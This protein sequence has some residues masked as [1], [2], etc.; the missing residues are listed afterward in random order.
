MKTAKLI[1]TTAVVALATLTAASAAQ[2]SGPVVNG[3]YSKTLH[4]H[5]KSWDC[6]ELTLKRSQRYR[7]VVEHIDPEHYPAV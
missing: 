1:L 5:G 3:R 2:A 7:V 4:V 6:L